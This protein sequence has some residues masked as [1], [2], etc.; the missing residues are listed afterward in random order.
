MIENIINK[1]TRL[2]KSD[3]I[4]LISAASES[5]EAADLCLPTLSIFSKIGLRKTYLNYEYTEI[6]DKN[7]FYISN[8]HKT[9]L[10]LFVDSDKKIIFD[11]RYFTSH[12]SHFVDYIDLILERLESVDIKNNLKPIDGHYVSM[13]KWFISYGHFKDEAYS[14]GHFLNV[15]PDAHGWVALLDYPTDDRLNYQSFQANENYKKIEKYIFGDKSIN[16]YD[17]GENIVHLKN[18][19]IV[20]NKINS[21]AFHSFPQ[22]ISQK[23]RANIFELNYKST[24][25]EYLPAHVMITRSNSYRDI[26][27]KPEIENFLSLSG[28]FVLNPENVSYEDLVLAVRSASVVVMFYGS[29]MTNMV[30]LQPNTRVIILKS[31]SYM[32][33]SLDLWQKV[34]STYNLNIIELPAVDNHIDQGA[35]M[36]LI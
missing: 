3:K 24:I 8:F 33:E 22:Y 31:A 34:I 32:H 29:A 13:Q 36:K 17:I 1:I 6:I 15:C 19:I 12:F 2:P 30:Y 5:F 11:S 27:N 4:K 23:I 18:L 35:L 9:D 7:I 25:F 26:G 20:N 21:K 14:L 16:A 10:S 28:F